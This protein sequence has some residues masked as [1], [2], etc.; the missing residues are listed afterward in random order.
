MSDE[1][2]RVAVAHRLG[3]K[4]VNPTPAHVAK[5]WIPEDFMVYA[6]EGV[7]RAPASLSDE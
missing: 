7:A 3:Y 6:A 1:A 2:V 5:Q 4:A